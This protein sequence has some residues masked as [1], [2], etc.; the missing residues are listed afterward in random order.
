MSERDRQ[1]PYD[2]NQQYGS[3]NR[4]NEGSDSPRQANQWQSDD[5]RQQGGGWH[6]DTDGRDSTDDYTRDYRLSEQGGSSRGGYRSSLNDG[7]SR[8]DAY[9]YGRDRDASRT[10]Y[11]QHNDRSQPGERG[12][13]R[14][15]QG[16]SQGRQDQQ[17]RYGRQGQYGSRGYGDQDYGR[18]DRSRQSSGGAVGGW[19]DFDASGGNDFGSFTSEDYGGRD[20]YNRG[21]GL[22][23]GQRSSESYRPSYGV[24]S[25]FDRDDD[26]RASRHSRDNARS[27]SSSSQREYGDWRQYGESRGFLERAGDEIASWFGD[28]EASRRRDRDRKDDHSGRGPA[29]YKRSDERIQDDVNDHLTHDWGVDASDITVTVKDGDVTLDG[30][31]DSR[32]AKRRAEDS[33][34]RVSGVKHVQNNL[35]VK[36][37][38]PASFG[39]SGYGQSAASGTTGQYGSTTQPSATGSSSASGLGSSGSTTGS[40]ASGSSTTTGTASSTTGGIG[41]TATSGVIGTSG[42]KASDKSS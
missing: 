34:E 39:N 31:V 24:S 35:R 41:S 18:Q 28:E 9:G 21:G 16:G 40:S 11:G 42:T 29:N 10:S 19:R 6:Q 1:N 25:W 27:G 30:T 23:G 36:D 2:R 3:G 7:D 26:D 33:A 32:Q 4:G 38:S 37:N 20:F 14:D 8:N 22:T 17:N 5:Y 15:W 13:Y 12:Q